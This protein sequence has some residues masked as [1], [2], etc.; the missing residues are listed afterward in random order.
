ME[1][2][3][4]HAGLIAYD[5]CYAEPFSRNLTIVTAC[6]DDFEIYEDLKIS[7]DLILNGYVKNPS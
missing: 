5:F 3:D 2:L 4:Y 6:M 7:N 1:I